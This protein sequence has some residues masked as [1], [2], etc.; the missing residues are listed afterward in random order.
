[1]FAHSLKII[2]RNLRKR[3]GISLI[4]IAGLTIGVT[5]FILIALFVQDELSYDRHHK[6]AGRIYRVNVRAVANETEFYSATSCTPMAQALI[7]EFPEVEASTKV[8]RFGIPVV[9]YED[10]VFSEERFWS[11]DESFFDVFSVPFL[12]GD[13][14][15]ALI[16][17][18]SVVLTRS[19]AERYFG[20]ENPIGKTLNTD[21]RR[22]YVVT[23]VIE[24]VPRTSHFRYDFLGSMNTFEYSRSQNWISNNDYTYFV[25]R[26]GVAHREFEEKMQSLIQ[27]YVYPQVKGALG[28]TPDE[29]I[30]GGGFFAYYIQSLTD[31]HLRSHLQ[32]EIEA[33]SDISYVY[34]FSVL[35]FAILLI[36]CINYINLSTAQSATRGRE[37]G[38]RK[39]VG[40]TANAL[41]GQFISEAVFLSVLAVV[42]S[43]PIIE[44][45][46][47]FFNNLTG[48]DLHIPYLTNALTLPLLL[49][50]GLAVGLLAGVYPAFYLSSFHPVAVLKGESS[51]KGKRS[52]MRNALVVFQFS[53]SIVL[54]IG[55]LVVDRQLRYIQNRNLGFSRD[56]VV[57]IHKVDDLGKQFGAFK[58]ELLGFPAVA[59]AA[60][61]SDL[62]GASFGDEL[63]VPANRPQDQ[64]Q[65]IW[66]MWADPDFLATYKIEL[67]A[68]SFFPAEAQ[69]E[70]RVVVLNEAAV[71]ILGLVNPV[72]QLL[73]GMRET[74]TIIGVMKDFHFESLHHPIKPFLIQPLGRD[75]GGRYL[76]VRMATADVRKTISLIEQ[77]WRKYAGSQAFEYE[78]FDEHFARVYLSEQ[79]TGRVFFIF[80]LLA[81]SIACLGLFGLTAFITEQR[82]KEIGIRKV[83]GA[84]APQVLF[85]L[86]RQFAF[87]VL[88]ANIIAWPVAYWITRQWLQDFAYRTTMTAWLFA[89]SAG[90]ALLVALLTVSFQ[91]V[92]AALANP[93]DS[94]RY[95]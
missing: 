25:L 77:T 81:V 28:V 72:G 35:A 45:I 79:K 23:G 36:S 8:H 16:E 55:T 19:T 10:K 59:S 5:G 38:I 39:T 6:N 15:T 62:M 82:T 88:I 53:V 50:I 65:L 89:L 22:D 80:S 95:E 70:R 60:N 91:S 86:T 42:V 93:V 40:S 47:P 33:N 61:T 58:Q 44:M 52:W 68:G 41:K 13:P 14:K 18:N 87:L 37:V 29:F 26:E 31:I 83:L 2:L 73:I 11:A 54:I 75:G 32:H 17:P 3:K 57:I 30:A 4:N 66:R 34:I 9:R 92:R 49:G 76:S 85:L 1:M 64:K 48:K 7:T 63:F 12:K 27:K 24:D 67:A 71:K 69:D 84:S 51:G 20:Q 56:Q 43:L 78:F 46:L 94:L 21:R 74:H 90:L